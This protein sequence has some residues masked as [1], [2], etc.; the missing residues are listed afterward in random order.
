V[1]A[2][3]GEQQPGPLA[4]EELLPHPPDRQHEETGEPQRVERVEGAEQVGGEPR[5][6]LGRA[7]S[8]T[9]PVGGLQHA[10]VPAGIGQHRGRD[11]AVV[12]AADH[13]GVSDLHT[14]TI[15]PRVIDR[16]T[17]GRPG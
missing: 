6:Q 14:A 8:A 10:H 16:A 12:P 2:V 1:P 9:E 11:E 13:D 15:T 7:D 4:R 3:P 5:V 17:C